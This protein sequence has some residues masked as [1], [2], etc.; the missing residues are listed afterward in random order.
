MVE[1]A[2]MTS[3]GAQGD[4]TSALSHHGGAINAARALYPD[5]QQPWVDLST[6]INPVPY[7]VGQIPASAFCRL[8]EASEIAALEQRAR[9]A[10]GAPDAAD[11]VAAPGTQ[12]ILQWLPRLFPAKRVGILTPTYSEHQK[13]WRANGAQV[14][15]A[16]SLAEA[17]DCDAIVVVNPNNPDGR[18]FTPGD[19]AQA[20][21]RLAARNGMLIVDEAFMEAIPQNLSLAP[22]LPAGRAIVLRSFGKIYGLA[23]LRLGFAIAPHFLGARLRE[24]LGPWAVSGPAVDIGRRALADLRWRTATLQR[25]LDDA[26]RL[27]ALLRDAGFEVIGGTA[28]FRLAGRTDAQAWFQR[29][30]RAGV[31]TRPFADHPDRLRFGLPK[32]PAEWERLTTALSHGLS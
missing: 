21:E 1:N 27:D 14:L 3:N 10:Y 17:Q 13:C 24:A 2:G 29:L 32:Q 8:P 19:L 7:P 20:G 31:L 26:A 22:F 4:P 12:T 9:A 23:G 18:V 28:L 15:A 5:A 30:C 11:I 25:L 16:G 6:G